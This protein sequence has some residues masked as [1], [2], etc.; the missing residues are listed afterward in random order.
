MLT[1]RVVE[2]RGLLMGNQCM[3]ERGEFAVHDFRQLM[4]RQADA[5]VR[6]AVLLKIV[7]ADFLGAVAAFNLSP[8]LGD[9]SC[10]LFFLL[11]FIEARAKY[12]HGFGAVFDLRFLIL[13]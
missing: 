1:R 12:A 10:L 11:Q 6:Y 5:M 4:Q 2:A 13:L 3:L 7:S 9:D 8:A